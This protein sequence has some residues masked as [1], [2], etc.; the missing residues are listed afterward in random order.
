[1]KA[2]AEPVRRLHDRGAFRDIREIRVHSFVIVADRLCS[3]RPSVNRPTRPAYG[4]TLPPLICSA[5][6]TAL[7]ALTMPPVT[8]SAPNAT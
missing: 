1:M 7:Y 5:I 8:E 4:I 6:F 3:S 2:S